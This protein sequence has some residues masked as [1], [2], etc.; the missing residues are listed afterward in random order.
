MHAQTRNKNFG[1]S[2]GDEC[3]YFQ[4]YPFFFLTIKKKRQFHIPVIGHDLQFEKGYSRDREEKY[5]LQFTNMEKM[6]KGGG[7]VVGIR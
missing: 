3:G 4:F 5:Y 1:N 2:K 6:A 7:T